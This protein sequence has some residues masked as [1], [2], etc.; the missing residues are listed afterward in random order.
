MAKLI[1]AFRNAA[2]A[3]KSAY[4]AATIVY[5]LVFILYNF[6]LIGISF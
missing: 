5:L 6:G 2:N 3:P 4:A 1:F